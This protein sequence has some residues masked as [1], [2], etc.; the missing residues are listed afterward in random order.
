VKRPKRIVNPG[1]EALIRG[2]GYSSLERFAEAVNHRGWE[3][4]GLKTMYDHITVQR[5]L[6]GSRSQ[7]PDVVAAVLSEGWGIP[8]PVEVLWPELRHGQPS[9]P[10]HLQPWAAGRTLDELGTF[11][12]GDMLTRR[13]TLTEAVKIMSGP[14]LLAP[15]ARWLGVEPG[16][17]PGKDEGVRRIGPSDVEAIERSV[18]YFAATDAEIGGALSREA[19]VGQLK[20][21]V[22]LAQHASYGERT[23]N[24]LLAAIGELSGLV[25][26][27]C[28]DS[29]M[30]GPAQRYSPTDSKPPASPAT[31]APHCWSSASCRTWPNRCAGLGALT[32]RSTYT[33]L[34][35]ASY[36]PTVTGSTCCARCWRATGPTMGCA[37][38]AAPA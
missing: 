38:S 19:A 4:H 7:N 34:L 18:R 28:H 5:W 37:V 22:D 13:E 1:L 11:V 15:I 10:A 26:W 31:L 12:R 27:L 29:N 14:A 36:R 24:R 6:A 21:A 2:A 35:P 8:V 33:I 23:G 9:A 16:H 3:M 32:S 30:P 25:G 17:L 20:Y